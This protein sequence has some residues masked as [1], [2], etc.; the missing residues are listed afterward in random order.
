MMPSMKTLAPEPGEN[1]DCRKK[2]AHHARDVFHS[3]MLKGAEYEKP[4]GMP[5]L[6]PAYADPDRIIAFSDAMS[7]KW[8]DFDC[9]VHFFEDDCRIER[10]WNNPK[11]YIGKLGKFQGVIGLDYSVCW[12]FPA[13]LKDYNHW[14]NS[15]CTYW[16]QQH[17][18]CAVPQARC[19]DGDYES[20][21]AGFPKNSTIAIGARSMVRDLA[22]RAV[23]VKSVE[24]IVDFLEPKNLLWYGSD[25]YG[26]ADY[27]RSKGIPVHMYPAKGR[28]N[29]DH[30]GGEL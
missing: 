14:R 27:P 24:N 22:D 1:P 18:P 20:V 26:V 25:Q 16:L 2:P 8:H 10:F 29:L 11:A 28:G 7:P 3:W 9:F 12:D 23:L 21:L 17:L 15:V 5:K 6:A 13:A 19:E 30:H 4:L